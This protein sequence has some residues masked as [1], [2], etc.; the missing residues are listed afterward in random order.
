MPAWLITLL[1]GA[2]GAFVAAW[3]G[4]QLGFR[5]TKKE[6][7]LDRRITWHEEAVQS[8]G[9]YEESL[10]RLRAYSMNV[11][12]VQRSRER[13][14]NAPPPGPDDVPRTIKAPPSLWA[15]LGETERRARAALR[16]ADLYTNERTQVECSSALSNHVNMAAR[17]WLDVSPEPEILWTDLQIKA[18]STA[19][20][21][22]RIQESLR[23]VLELDGYVATLLGPKYRKWRTLRRLK[24][25]EAEFKLRVSNERSQ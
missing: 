20:I 1:S 10:E 3:A 24:E 9:E 13:S 17:Q 22:Q 25:L 12:V 19:T 4:A 18:F 14:T 8:L 5:R 6:K 15:D 16:L 11:L 2:A 7:A 21:R 23:V